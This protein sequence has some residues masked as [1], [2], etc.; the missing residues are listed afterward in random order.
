[1][2]DDI[3]IPTL[4]DGEAVSGKKLMSLVLVDLSPYSPC[5]R[6]LETLSTA[7]NTLEV[8]LAEVASWDQ[9]TQKIPATMGIPPSCSVDQHP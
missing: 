6:T 1:M 8:Y 9:P 5:P 7:V 4:I 2:E 3:E